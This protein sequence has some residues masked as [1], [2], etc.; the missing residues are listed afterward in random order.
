MNQVGAWHGADYAVLVRFDER[1][2]PGA[3]EDTCAPIRSIEQLDQARNDGVGFRLEHHAL[4][5]ELVEQ[6]RLHRNAH[7][8][9][10]I[11]A[12]VLDDDRD[13]DGL[14][15]ARV[16]SRQLCFA[17]NDGHWRDGH[18]RIRSDR[19]GVLRVTLRDLG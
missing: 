7:R 2:A 8:S 1:D 13:A 11:T 15:D 3:L 16:I 14:D 4:R 12:R 18:Y 19:L 5:P 10:D 17:E 6:L 9:A